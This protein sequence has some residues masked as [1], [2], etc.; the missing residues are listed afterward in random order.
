MAQDIAFYKDWFAQYVAGYA[1]E[2][3][4]TQRYLDL[5][6]D[7]TL[8]VFEN[9]SLIAET[10]P[11]PEQTLK[12]ALL[13]ALFHDVGRFEQFS[14]YHTYSDRD[15]VNH[16]YL[17]SRILRSENVLA[18]EKKEIRQS[19][20]AVVALHNR[21]VLPRAIPQHIREATN[22][23][24]DSDKL[25]IFPILVA[26]FIHDGSKNDVVT[27]GLQDCP[28]AYSPN[29]LSNVLNGESVRYAEMQ[30][31]NDFKLLL[32]SW[33]FNLEFSTSMQILYKRGYMESLLDTLP[34]LPEMKKVKHAVRNEMQRVL[35]GYLSEEE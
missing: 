9:A 26:N 15:S 28:S 18:E 31:V 1:Q 25:D 10:L 35:A 19:V 12:I 8:R 29:A 34:D 11:L 14:L 20:R 22:I 27:M 7:H 4:E 2:D 17:G 21:L 3:I 13:G 23:V 6:R 24:R 30:Y 32:S 16:G 33:V 5:K